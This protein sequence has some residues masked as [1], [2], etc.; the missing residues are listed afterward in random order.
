MLR[1]VALVLW[2][3]GWLMPAR[4]AP[5]EVF[6]ALGRA[7]IAAQGVSLMAQ[8]VDDGEA[9]LFSHNES[10]ALT[11]ASTTKLVTS[12]AALDVLGPRYRWQTKAYLLG[13]LRD[14]VL[15]GDLLIVGGGDARLS[16]KD[17]QRWFTKM[18]SKGLREIR[19]N[20][21]VNRALFKTQ[22][23]D[24]VN[25]PVPT[26]ENPHHAWPDALTVDEG[27]ITVEIASSPLGPV[28]SYRPRLEGVSIFNQLQV[29]RRKCSAL[30]A[31]V[32]VAFEEFNPPARLLVQGEWAPGCGPARIVVATL[33]GSR[34]TP[35]ALAAAWRDAGGLLSGEV[36]QGA[37]AYVMPELPRGLK[38][39]AAHDSAPL[40]SLLRDMN[41]WSNNLLARHM[42]L[43][44]AK[45]FPSR[46][47]TLAEARKRMNQWLVR[48]GLA[49]D[50]LVIDNGSGLS[51]AERGRADVLVQLLRKAWHGPHAQDVFQ[52]LP[53]AGE[54]GTLSTRF[55]APD[56]RGQAHL[57]T[58]TLVGARSLA[59]YVKG[60]S[61]RT[62]AVAAII[63]DPKADKGLGALDAFIEW[64]MLNG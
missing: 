5:D 42:M 56:V 51:H 43:S 4:A 18:Q 41:K 48:Q 17:L 55:K 34:F 36:I 13:P 45:G 54:D 58:G 31:P 24:H 10:R 16:S 63:N 33:P 30:R 50:D 59:G 22:A 29:S 47:A 40:N 39:F 37:H 46:P 20:I 25:T 57:K 9:P 35:L 38:P 11:L 23:S 53:V 49:Q 64:V 52:S 61:G 28:L 7:G 8:N 26:P 32:S 15:Q 21:L 14:G 62:Y 1:L 19:G 3:G 44:M 6:Q 2:L 12:L 60:R 27:V